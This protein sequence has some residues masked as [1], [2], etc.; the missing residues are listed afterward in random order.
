V[1]SGGFELV[2]S[3]STDSG[4]TIRGGTIRGVTIRGGTFEVASGGSTGSSPVTFAS[5]G[6]GTLQLDA[7][8]SFGGLIAGF[9]APITSTWRT[10]PSGRA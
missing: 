6:G 10:S 2:E 8:V 5:S 9:G 3:G 4:V 1:G 7:S